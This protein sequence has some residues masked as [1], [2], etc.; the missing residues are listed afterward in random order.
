MDRFNQIGHKCVKKEIIFLKLFL[1][2]SIFI[3]V[4]L[5]LADYILFNKNLNN[6]VFGENLTV[7]AASYV[8]IDGSNCSVICGEN[9]HKKLPMASTTKIMTAI[10]AIENLDLNKCIKINKNAIGVEGSSIY[11]NGD[12]EYKILDLVYGLMLRS[13]NDAAEALAY[14][15]SGSI[16]S[17]A[18][19]MNKKAKELG[20]ENTNFVNPHGLHDDNHYTTAYDLAVISSYAM[21]NKIFREIVS[22]KVHIMDS[23][24]DIFI[25]KNKFLSKFEDANGIKTGYT[26]VAGRCLVS[27]A[28]KGGIQLICVVLNCPDMWNASINL[29]D[30]AYSKYDLIELIKKNDVFINDGNIKLYL[31]EDLLVGVEK[32]SS[33]TVSYKF[34]INSSNCFKKND[35]VGFIDVYLNNR[36][37]FSKKIYTMEAI[38]SGEDIVKLNSIIINLNN[39]K[40]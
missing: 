19:L 38:N 36:L 30:Y 22:T 11:L 23:T 15:I 40:N 7:N 34:R 18:Q 1:I 4:T 14:E 20:L 9:I 37:L 8:V 10:L 35:H 33:N 13:G 26:K 27:S 31:K 6:E 16:E 24:E 2:V 32:N 3:I 12:K 39:G 29:L 25:N 28:L 17:F 5:F 21:K